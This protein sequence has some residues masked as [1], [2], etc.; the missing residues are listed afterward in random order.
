MTEDFKEK[1]LS[2]LCGKLEIGNKK[3]DI[4]WEA[5]KSTTNNLYDYLEAEFN[6]NFEISSCDTTLDCAG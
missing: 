1:I 3:E 2:Y 6:P 4:N 5:L